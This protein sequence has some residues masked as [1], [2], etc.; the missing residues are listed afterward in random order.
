MPRDPFKPLNEKEQ[1]FVHHFVREH[2]A[3]AAMALVARKCRIPEDEAQRIWKRAHVQA[4]IQRRKSHIEVEEDRLIA[5]ERVRQEEADNRR[6]QVSLNDAEKAIKAVLT[7]DPAEHSSAVLEAVKLVMVY[8]GTIRD[9]NRVKIATGALDP[10]QT[11]LAQPVPA[12]PG[13]SFYESIFAVERVTPAED[14]AAA[15]APAPLFPA[16]APEPPKAAK[17]AQSNRPAQA[18]QAAQA[19]QPAAAFPKKS[20]AK[21]LDVEIT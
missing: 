19:A 12:N 13:P 15:P 7:L 16:D 8:T 10:G 9:G 18:A 1:R 14:G 21:H 17:P 2:Y 3:E 5:R 4:E 6:D 11:P 20:T